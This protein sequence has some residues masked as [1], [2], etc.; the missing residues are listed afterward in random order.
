MRKA[1][2]SMAPSPQLTRNPSINATSIVASTRRT[3]FETALCALLC[4]LAISQVY[5][6][7]ATP[8]AAGTNPIATACGDFNADG[9]IDAATVNQGIPGKLGLQLGN[10][11]GGFG[12]AVLSTVGNGPRALAAADFNGDGFL[13]V[14]TAN[15]AG[16]SLSLALGGVAG[17]GAPL[18]LA[19]GSPAQWVAAGDLD[20]DGDA[21]LV[22]VSGTNSVKVLLGNGIGGFGAAVTLPAGSLPNFVLITDVNADGKRDLVTTSQGAGVVNVLLGTGTGGFGAPVSFPA[23]FPTA[24]AAGDFDADGRLDLATTSPNTD[25][26]SILRGIGGGSFG[27]PTTLTLAAG[28]S[29]RALAIADLDG[30]AALDI[31]CTSYNTAQ[32]SVFLGTGFGGFASP[33]P[34]NV[35]ASPAAIALAQL[36]GDGRLDAVTGN[37]IGQS[38]SVLLNQS[39]GATFPCAPLVIA[40]PIVPPKF[41]RQVTP[42]RWQAADVLWINDVVPHNKIDDAIDASPAT[43][44]DVLVNFK[45]CVT[46]SEASLLEGISVASSVTRV[47]RTITT[48]AM[49]GVDL[50]DAIQIAALPSVAFIERRGTAA[51]DLDTS[52]KAI[53]VAASTDY[54]TSTVQYAYPSIDGAGVTIAILDSGVDNAGHSA[55]NTVPVVGGLLARTGAAIDPPDEF[56]HGT[57]VA[58]IALGRPVLFVWPYRGVA[59]GASLI[60]V[61]VDSGSGVPTFIPEGLDGVLDRHQTGVW[62]VDVINM[63]LSMGA[64]SDGT[65]AL[66]ALVDLADAMGIVVV[67][68]VGNSGPSNTF[69]TSPA[70]ATRS[71]TVA[72]S[73]DLDTPERSDDDLYKVGGI[74]KTSKG[75]RTSDGDTDCIDERKPE[76][77]APGQSITG[78]KATIQGGGGSAFF[79]KDGSSLAAPHV[80]GLAALILQA[81]PGMNPSS[82]KQLIIQS[83]EAKGSPDSSCDPIWDDQW[84]WGLVDGFKAFQLL[85][86]GVDL[87]FPDYGNYTYPWLSTDITT[88]PVT[89]VAGSTTKVTVRIRNPSNGTIFGVRLNFGIHVFTGTATEFHDIGTKV[90]SVPPGD[91][92]YY[93]TNWKPDAF[94]HQ[95]AQVDIGYGPD[96]NPTNNVT[97]RN[98]TVAMSP[99]HFQVRNTLTPMPAAITFQVGCED[100]LTPGWRVFVEPAELVLGPDDCPVD[101]MVHAISPLAAP[102]GET[103]KVHIATRINGQLAGG[104]S[105]ISTKKDCN[106]NSIDDWF[107][108]QSGASLDA[109]GNGVPDECGPPCGVI[110][111]GVGASPVN[112][113]DLAGLGP[114]AVGTTLHLRVTQ[115]QPNGLTFLALAVGQANLSLFGGVLLVNPAGLVSIQALPA[116]A[117]GVASAFLGI[118]SSPTLVGAA[119][120]FQAAGLDASQPAG[121]ALSNGLHVII[122][123]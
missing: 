6:G 24:V 112:A 42:A 54:P 14:A 104:V 49:S 71:I 52:V 32:V 62:H 17:F 115:A 18:T 25:T 45:T 46:P 50:A 67:T 59:P 123:Q 89:P 75:P 57:L 116:N 38:L 92:N 2:I 1:A 19:L 80:A 60:D 40:E 97:Q 27:G 85:N 10:G 122:C 13:D 88:D 41:L 55:F 65:D 30:D 16:G 83:A 96:T 56:G 66:S 29:P 82:V 63:S 11:A 95:C 53:K 26:L 39:T 93:E 119:V 8:Y 111:Y 44:V 47:F 58:S 51:Y 98:L 4:P 101:V 37:F 90:V 76:V 15:L 91:N 73:Y 78:A 33:Q 34:S 23:G 48:V 99:V 74:I 28:A 121:I 106:G 107:D 110:R 43:R 94:E 21:D 70:A 31:A 103:M 109:N 114:A 20:N 86:T 22:A 100:T 81:A 84:G 5:P 9:K 72:G 113:L 87:T 68:A 69:L 7:S 12:P 117:Q 108:I 36:D 64:P 102:A 120:D 118:P 35:G 105:V 77:A 79:T 3:I 61:N